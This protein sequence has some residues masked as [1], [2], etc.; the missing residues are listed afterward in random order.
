MHVYLIK[1]SAPGPFKDYK[2]A[3]GGPSQNIFAAAAATPDDVEVSMCDETIGMRVALESSADLVALFFHTPD[4]PHAYAL[5]D[6]FTARGKTV[7]FGGLHTSLL[8][9]EAA[10]H[11]DALI[12]GELE[13]IWPELLADA[14]RGAL[15]TRYR[16]GRPV[17]MRDL[18]PW[19]TDIISPQRYNYTWSVMVT[20]GCPQSCDFCTVPVFFRHGFQRRPIEE[21]VAEVRALPEY[22]WVELHSDNLT[23]DRDYALAL[24]KAL[25]PL[26]RSW[27]GESTIKMA[28]DEALVQAAAESG[29]KMLL[30]GIETPSQ[31]ALKE[32]SKGFVRTEKIK[33]AISIFHRHGIQVSSSMIFG[34]DSHTPEIFEDSY[35][36]CKEIG[37]DEVEPVIQIPFPGTPLFKRLEAEGRILTTDWSKYDG[38]N[39]VYQPKQMTPEQLEEGAAWF[40]ERAQKDSSLRMTTDGEVNPK[41]P[42]AWL[43]VAAVTAGLALN[44]Y[45]I[46]GALFI[47][48]ALT[49][50]RSGSTHLLETVN[51][52]ENPVLFSVIVLMWGGLAM[53]SL[54]YA[55]AVH[56]L[57]AAL[58]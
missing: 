50:L 49:D 9:E 3:T 15:K 35:A 37:L 33:E 10:A 41:K 17:D 18:K 46:W 32:V 2:R 20:R 45:W 26:K 6:A 58:G 22:V 51:I 14:E 19:P 55:P 23:A 36:F 8:P 4:A 40:Y 29:C 5:A 27:F 42:M 31:S 54:W 30:I 11:A 53:W 56:E 1:A 43:G 39:A 24:F 12:L 47:M 16:S 13:G 52:H 21:I 28:K 57:L 48:W 38:A 44:W 25:A 7:V 34:F